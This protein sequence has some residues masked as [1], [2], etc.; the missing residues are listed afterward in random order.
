[1]KKKKILNI[2]PKEP[3]AGSSTSMHRHDIQHMRHTF[4]DVF[5][6]DRWE[7]RI[8]LTKQD[9]A[10]YQADYWMNAEELRMAPSGRT[11]WRV[12]AKQWTGMD[13]FVD[14]ELSEADK[15]RIRKMDKEGQDQIRKKREAKAKE[16]DRKMKADFRTLP[17]IP[18]EFKKDTDEAC[19][20]TPIW[21]TKKRR[22]AECTCGRCGQTYI[23]RWDWETEPAKDKETTCK[24]CGADGVFYWG[25]RKKAF[26]FFESFL[27]PQKTTEGEMVLRIFDAW[28][29]CRK[30][31]E[32]SFTLNETQ[33][34]FLT[35]GNVRRYSAWYD[36]NGAQRGWRTGGSELPGMLVWG[37]LPEDTT[38]RF[39]DFGAWVRAMKDERY[40]VTFENSGWLMARTMI[41]QARRQET[42]ML[43][44]TGNRKLAVD[45]LNGYSVRI[46]KEG[47]MADRLQITPERLKDLKETEGGAARLERYQE[48]KKSGIFATRSD[49]DAIWEMLPGYSAREKMK[50]L[51]KVSKYVSIRQLLNRAEHYAAEYVS[52]SFALSHYIDYLVM[53][54]E[55]GYE[56][57]NDVYLRPRSLEEAHD[58][59][60]FEKNRKATEKHMQKMLEEYPNIKRHEKRWAK[61]YSWKH[62]GLTIRPA[63]DAAEMVL[64]GRLLYHCVGS[65]VYLKRMDAGESVILFLRQQEKE[66]VP[67]VT[68]E[69]RG[70]K[71]LQWYGKHDKKPDEDRIDRW[72]QV[73]I[74]HLG[75]KDG[76]VKGPKLSGLQTAI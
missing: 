74:E 68:V 9:F 18:A 34:I 10:A 16:R 8:V 5:D 41:M 55:L 73:Y 49:W 37:G 40:V 3:E 28:K 75:G 70:E 43:L 31:Q 47:N 62:D 13:L 26:D 69:I 72:L 30:G 7:M 76:K 20:R 15:D 53:R 56:M 36:W 22:T 19:G 25:G 23:Y 39:Y 52:R 57:T 51:K 60:V 6:G 67:Y 42:E 11:K 32:Q 24:R 27:L 45:I 63:A 12:A 35:P 17:T 29:K 14:T 59:M 46:R 50:N 2:P 4:L 33:R 1:M 66:E 44:K 38:M 61:R 64:E 54:K 48:E 21:Y 71:I 65:S 58:A